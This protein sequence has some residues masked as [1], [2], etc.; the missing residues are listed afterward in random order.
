MRVCRRS[1]HGIGI[2][3]DDGKGFEPLPGDRVFPFIPQAGKAIGFAISQ[4]DGERLF[5]FGVE[6]LPFIKR[7]G[8]HQAAAAFGR[9]AK[10][11]R[12]GHGFRTRIDGAVADLDVF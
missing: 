3:G 1:D 4:G 10:S 12:G 2:G 11:G 7:I 8:R 6:F 5:V 9:L